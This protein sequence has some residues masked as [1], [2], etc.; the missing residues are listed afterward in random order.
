MLFNEPVGFKNNC[1]VRAAL[2]DITY[3]P[4]HVHQDILETV[5][6]LDGK[7]HIF[8]GVHELMLSSGD[9]YFFNPRDCHKLE[10][11]SD[12]GILLTV[13][14]DL[15]RY[16]N[17][18]RRFDKNGRYDI[19]RDSFFICDSFRYENKS[20]LDIR[21][22]RFLL[23]RMLRLYRIGSD[24]DLE[25]LT[26]EF[27]SHI[28]DHYQ[29]YYYTR[30]E[31][32]RYMIVQQETP[33]YSHARYKR[34]YRILDYLYENARQKITLKEVAEKEYLNPSYLSTHIKQVSGLTFSQFLSITRCEDAEAMLRNTEK[35]IDKIAREVGFSDRN[36]LTNQFRRWFFKTPAQYRRELLADLSH[37]DRV[38]FDTF[39]QDLADLIIESYLDSY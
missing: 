26:K 32:G 33:V 18:Y 4:Y 23:A 25:G 13:Q 7:Y 27:L 22:L 5:C 9:V 10:R 35:T 30:L 19:T 34:I 39:D 8:N 12:S 21:H 37:K 3:Y 20:Y 2:E 24:L 6:V 31:D 1:G 36:H 15:N 16:K 14:I 28:L 29:D 11:V 38:R 17:H